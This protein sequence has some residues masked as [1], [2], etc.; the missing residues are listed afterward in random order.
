[1]QAIWTSR[2]NS[3]TV[4]RAW[5]RGDASERLDAHA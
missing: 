2:E 3:S 1:M 5:V 4:A